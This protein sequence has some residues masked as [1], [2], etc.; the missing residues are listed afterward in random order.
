[1]K[2]AVLPPIQRAAH[3]AAVRDAVAAERRRC[4]EIILGAG[5]RDAFGKLDWPYLRK[6][7]VKAIEAGE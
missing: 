5:S 2:A 7:I 3:E 1:M 4:V 6:R